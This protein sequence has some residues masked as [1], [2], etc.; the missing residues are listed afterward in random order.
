MLPYFVN[1]FLISFFIFSQRLFS[2]IRPR[3]LK[4][5]PRLRGGII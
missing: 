5:P 1:T 4:N 3:P 2:A